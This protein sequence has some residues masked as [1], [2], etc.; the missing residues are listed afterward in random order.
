MN[1][2]IRLYAPEEVSCLDSLFVSL[3]VDGAEVTY[4]ELRWE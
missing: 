3:F 1:K 4:A 2:V